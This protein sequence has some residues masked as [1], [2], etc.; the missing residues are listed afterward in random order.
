MIEIYSILQPLNWQMII[1][2]FLIGWFYARDLKKFIKEIEDRVEV[3]SARSDKLYE[4][5]CIIQ[6]D[7]KDE[8]LS[9]K[10]E[11]YKF[12]ENNKK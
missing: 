5:F 12:M 10:T 9:L 1:A 6:K 2:M 8:L 11:H 4:M 3:Q 7:M